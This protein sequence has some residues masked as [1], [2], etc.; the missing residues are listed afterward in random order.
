MPVANIHRIHQDTE[1]YMWYGTTNG[2]LCR[3]NGY[4]I[5]VFRADAKT[6]DVMES[7][8]VTCVAEDSS[9]CIWFGTRVGP[10]RLDKRTYKISRPKV[11]EGTTWAIIVDHAGYIWLNT[12]SIVM[13]LSPDGEKVLFSQTIDT[14][15]VNAI[16]EDS[17]NDIWLMVPFQLLK[18]DKKTNKFLPQKTDT[19]IDPVKMLEDKEQHGYWMSSWNNGIV[20]YNPKNGHITP[21]P[22]TCDSYQKSQVLDFIR[23]EHEG[24]FWVS[25]MCNLDLYEAVGTVLHPLPTSSFLSKENKILDFLY[26]DPRGNIWVSGFV[27]STFIVSKSNPTQRRITVPLM[28]KETGYPFMPCHLIIDNDSSLWIAQNRIG[29]MYYDAPNDRLTNLSDR[30]YGWGFDKSKKHKG[31]WMPQGHSLYLMESPSKIVMQ[32]D[33]PEDVSKVVDYDGDNLYVGTLNGVYRARLNH[34]SPVIKKLSGGTGNITDLAIS[35]EGEVFYLADIYKFHKITAQGKDIDLDPGQRC[36]I[37]ALTIAP[38]GT[39]WAGSRL[40]QLYMLGRGETELKPYTFHFTNNDAIFDI[41]VDRAGHVWFICDQYAREFNPNNNA[42]RTIRGADPQVGVCSFYSVE[43]IDGS[44]IA[45][46]GSG[47]AIVCQSSYALDRESNRDVRPRI[48]SYR[49]ADSLILMPVNTDHIDIP[50]SQSDIELYATTLQH[51]DANQISFA[52]KLEGHNKEWTYLP[53]GRNIIYL[54]NLP[55]GTYHLKLMATTP[56]GS[57]MPAADVLSIH[58]LPHWY[59]KWWAICLFL[60]LAAGLIYALRLLGVRIRNLLELQRTR[61]EFSLSEIEIAPTVDSILTDDKAFLKK[62][63]NVVERHIGNADYSVEQFSADMTMSRSTLTRRMQTLTQKSPGE[64][65]RD[66]RLKK[67]ANLLIHHPELTVAQIA[68]RVGFQTPSY[69]SKCFKQKF[70]VLPKQ[71]VKNQEESLSE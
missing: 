57:W 46:C 48:S 10:Y 30:N 4:Q 50:A 6:P 60:I 15:K 21:S 22:S 16:Y 65:M 59:E 1:G 42:Y 25:T 28:V 27:P 62:A 5:D 26:E 45:L 11:P 66:I 35:T 24:H 17:H 20:F 36:K 67:A 40:G 31:V 38:N 63:I 56:D 18:L 47:A 8:N 49:I 51:Y 53:Q 2:G 43:N 13:K 61:K 32:L 70:G 71:Y 12:K 19:G 58:R 55:R 52:Y 54:S 7:N 9:Q 64:F 68:E 41:S 33:F 39:V 34:G 14:W 44:H 29:V 23:D 69:F 3:D 37:L